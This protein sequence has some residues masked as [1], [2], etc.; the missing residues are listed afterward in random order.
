M[1]MKIYCYQG[2]ND[3]GVVIATKWRH[4][5]FYLPPYFSAL[6]T[7]LPKSLTSTFSP[8]AASV[9]V[10]FKRKLKERY[11]EVLRY[12]SFINAIQRP[13]LKFIIPLV[14]SSCLYRPTLEME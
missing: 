1:K 4:Y 10:K 11:R 13:D 9:F 5:V 8:I 2:Y 7:L 14:E 12:H 6:G 3:I